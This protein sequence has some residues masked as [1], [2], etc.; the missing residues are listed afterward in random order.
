MGRKRQE[1]RRFR[2]GAGEAPLSLSVSSLSV[3][4]LRLLPYP[5]ALLSAPSPRHGLRKSLP[6]PL[7]S[8]ALSSPAPLHGL[9][10]R[11]T[12]GRH[13]RAVQQ[14][15]VLDNGVVRHVRLAELCELLQLLGE[16][17][18]HRPQRVRRR[19]VHHPHRPARV[20]DAHRPAAA[21]RPG[22]GRRARRR[23]RHGARAAE[24][25]CSGRARSSRS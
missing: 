2:R 4:K 5:L 14:R 15:V 16:V 10:K 24:R 13:A 11:R 18:R 6:A 19:V 3:R 22:S 21:H 20:Q 8:P 1:V 12:V 23:R 9:R 25:A 7:S 17:V